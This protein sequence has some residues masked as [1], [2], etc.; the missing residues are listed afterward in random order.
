MEPR[1]YSFTK[2]SLPLASGRS[3]R[4]LSGAWVMGWAHSAAK[5]APFSA[6]ERR[7]RK[8]RPTSPTERAAKTAKVSK[9]GERGGLGEAQLAERLQR[10]VRDGDWIAAELAIPGPC[11]VEEVG[12]R[13]IERIE[14]L[15]EA[16][17]VELL[18]PLVNG[19]RERGAHTA[20]LVAQQ[21]EQP[22]GGPA[23]DRGDVEKGGDIERRE[24]SW[25]ARDHDHARPDDMPG[26][27][28]ERETGHP[29]AC[30]TPW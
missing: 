16:Q 26:A 8:I 7:I 24:E 18:A 15:V 28:I 1:C 13:R 6:T 30:P 3:S 25:R 11:L 27:D 23:H 19:L 20:A 5:G 29:V 12:H 17:A 21:R 10:H 9:I 2:E 22:H 4:F 14:P